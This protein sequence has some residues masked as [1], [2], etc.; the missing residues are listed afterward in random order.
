MNELWICE[1]GT[2]EYEEAL[3]LQARLCD[4]RK[5]EE[6][7]DTL[8]LL[9]HHPVYTRGR[10]SSDSDLPRGEDF[11]AA[12]GIEVVEVDR[13]G[14]VTYHGPGQLVGYPIMRI[15]DVIGYLRTLEAAIVAALAREG[16]AARGGVT[17]PTGVWAGERKIASIGVHVSRRVSTHGFAVNVDNDLEPFEWIV[18][19]GLD[20][21]AMTSLAAETAGGGSFEHFRET[22]A[23]EI[24]IAFGRTRHDVT[25]A[26]LSAALAAGVAG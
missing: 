5:A 2:V 23:E 19:C 10:R 3:A 8:L 17:R 22:V 7:P 11:Y 14:L 9:D 25:V 6:I 21:V 24:A 15:G 20:G 4:A 12:A 16:V 26:E 13:G 1:L 18:P